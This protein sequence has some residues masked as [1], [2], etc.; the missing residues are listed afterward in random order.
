M[1]SIISTYKNRYSQIIRSLPSYLDQNCVFDY[2]IIIVD[3]NSNDNGDSFISS[4]RTNKIVYAKCDGA[5]GFHISLARNIGSRV[6]KYPYFLFTDI[7]V[8]FNRNMLNFVFS[9][10]L[11]NKYVAACNSDDVFDVINGG[12]ICV[13]REKHASISGFDERMHGWGY[14]D[15]DYK[16][17]LESNGCKIEIIPDKY[18]TCMQHSDS[19]RTKQYSTTKQESWDSNKNLSQSNWCNPKYGEFPRLSI[20]KY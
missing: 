5:E 14:E 11:F 9:K 2:E 10:A 19:F 16:K 18:Y 12:L 8:L 15:I 6:A 1:I 13:H 4:F 17:R 3:Y 20:F 7:D